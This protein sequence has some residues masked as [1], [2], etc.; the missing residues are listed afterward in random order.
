MQGHHHKPKHRPMP[1]HISA[2]EPTRQLMTGRAG[3]ALLRVYLHQ[4]GLMPL[5]ER[6]FRPFRSRRGYPLASLL[7]QLLLY[8]MDGTRPCLRGL[9]EKRG[10]PGYARLIGVH[11]SQLISSHA[12]KRFFYRI[13]RAV[14]PALNAVL[15]RM[16]AA[17]LQR[18]A[19]ERTR[20][21]RPLRT[22]VLAMDSKVWKQP[23]ARVREGVCPTY[24]GVR[25]FHPLLVFWRGDVVAACFRP[26]N[27][28]THRGDDA[29]RL[30]EPL[31][32]TIRRV[33]GPGAR[34]FVRADAGFFDG[35]LFDWLAE[36][37]VGFLIGGRWD[38]ATRQA[39]ARSRF[40][41]LFDDGSVRVTATT[42]VQSR[43]RWSKPYRVI[44]TRTFRPGTQ[45]PLLDLEP[46]SVFVLHR[47]GRE[48]TAP[49]DLERWVRRYR[50][51]GRDELGFRALVDFW[52]ES[53]PF[54]RFAANQAFFFLLLLAFNLLRAF[55]EDSFED[56]R[57]HRAYPT[58]L[59]RRLLDFAGRI[60]RRGRRWIL[61]IPEPVYAALRLERV[62]VRVHHVPVLLC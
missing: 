1:T 3:L 20:A 37:G 59:R 30:L 39:C 9:D 11:L 46:R 27:A 23:G 28:H 35:Q 53:L 57:L 33:L 62:W 14:A 18:Y 42:F 43:P 48:P 7:S 29:R 41:P 56:P 4:R 24:R 32:A 40:V 21:G 51:R 26:G 58:T 5:L 22:V 61:K 19:A 45:P 49:L 60:V 25:G 54:K 34:I 38:K 8:L 13:P 31:F 55:A 36:Q 16:F 52:R 15:R 10:D 47:P 17:R 6:V 2:V 12:V 50:R 44:V